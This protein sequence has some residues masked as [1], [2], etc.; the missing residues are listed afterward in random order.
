MT[1]TQINAELKKLGINARLQRG[2]GYYYWLDASGQLLDAQ[3]VYVNSASQI[4]LDDWVRLAREA[5][6]TSNS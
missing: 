5:A 3:S 2:H 4:S 6:A 1:A